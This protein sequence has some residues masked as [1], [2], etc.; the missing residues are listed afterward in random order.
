MSPHGLL[1]S[2]AVVRDVAHTEARPGA[3]PSA[4]AFWKLHNPGKQLNTN[5]Q[6]TPTLSPGHSGCYPCGFLFMIF[7]KTEVFERSM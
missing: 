5:N 6:T 3:W 2:P 1:S 7:I 4:G